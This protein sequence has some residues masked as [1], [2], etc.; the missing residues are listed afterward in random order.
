MMKK[1]IYIVFVMFFMGA[2]SCSEEDITLNP[3]LADL[4]FEL[5]Q[6]E[7]GSLEEQI[8]SFYERYETFVLY[9][10]LMQKSL[11]ILG[12]LVPSI[13]LLR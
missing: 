7:E 10:I 1:Y 12:D 8:Y 6:G 13:G 4:P 9:R 2:V 5:P 3:E 11:I